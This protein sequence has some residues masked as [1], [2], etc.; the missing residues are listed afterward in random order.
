M[1]KN[2]VQFQKGL[3]LCDFFEQYGSEYKCHTALFQ[4]HW[5]QGYVCVLSVAML[6]IVS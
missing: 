5:P 4:L 3:S 1:P 6:A 2:L